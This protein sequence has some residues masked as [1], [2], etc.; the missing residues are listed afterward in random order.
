MDRSAHHARIGSEGRSTI[1]ETLRTLHRAHALT[2]L[3]DNHSRSSS[4]GHPGIHQL[5]RVYQEAA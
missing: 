2:L 3:F 1:V 4:V 5:L